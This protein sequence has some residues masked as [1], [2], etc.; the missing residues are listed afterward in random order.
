MEGV[1]R[2]FTNKKDL[3]IREKYKLIRKDVPPKKVIS[4]MIH[5]YSEKSAKYHEIEL[6]KEQASLLYVYLQDLILNKGSE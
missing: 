2:I 5:D 6:S 3:V 4:L 1:Y